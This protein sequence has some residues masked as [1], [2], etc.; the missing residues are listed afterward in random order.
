MEKVL[1]T[2]LSRM[3]EAMD[4]AQMHYEI[5]TDQTFSPD[6]R[7]DGEVSDLAEYVSLFLAPPEI[8]SQAATA[9]EVS[10]LAV[11]HIYDGQGQYLGSAADEGAWGYLA[12]GAR[13]TSKGDPLTAG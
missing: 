1:A 12:R 8:A 10:P 6:A 9:I 7:H 2:D 13:E 4:S 11:L 5:T 3:K